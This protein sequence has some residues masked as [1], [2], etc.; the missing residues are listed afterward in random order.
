MVKK[1]Q[2]SVSR[3][4]ESANLKYFNTD[5]FLEGT[6]IRQRGSLGRVFQEKG[7]FVEAIRLHIPES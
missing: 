3:F 4:A 2:L 5:E 1:P 7:R 6:A